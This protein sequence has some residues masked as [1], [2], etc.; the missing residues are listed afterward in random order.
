MAEDDQLLWLYPEPGQPFTADGH[1][2]VYCGAHELGETE[3]IG[4]AGIM[5]ED[6]L[7]PAFSRTASCSVSEGAR[8]VQYEDGGVINFT[9]HFR[10]LVLRYEESK[11][12]ENVPAEESSCS[13][14]MDATG[15]LYWREAWIDDDGDEFDEFH[16]EF[17]L[18]AL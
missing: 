13:S 6:Y 11:D 3:Y 16:A 4:G 14:G 1:I 7:V 18:Y 12:P 9:P 5:H 15:P 10:V 2:P 17:P 8:G